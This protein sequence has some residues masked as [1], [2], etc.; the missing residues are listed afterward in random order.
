MASDTDVDH[1]IP[2]NP[3]PLKPNQKHNQTMHEQQRTRQ[4]R[5]IFSIISIVAIV[6]LFVF[7]T[8][9]TV[10][11]TVKDGTNAGGWMTVSHGL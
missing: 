1:T 5:W 4:V 11:L 8:A 6:D 2:P 10:G 7:L 3:Q 9:V